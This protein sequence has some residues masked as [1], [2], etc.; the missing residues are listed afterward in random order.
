M[1]LY[2]CWEMQNEQKNFLF[3]L[4]HPAHYHNISVVAQKLSEL[5]HAI[6]LVV[7]EKDVLADLVKELPYET[8]YL[9]QKKGAG[10]L[11]LIKTVIK[12]EFQ[13]YRI[14]KKYKPNMMIGK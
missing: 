13:L 2:Y 1:V 9:G 5:G 7:R 8:I 4:G 3:Y 6:L 12:R 14:A 10:T 11:S